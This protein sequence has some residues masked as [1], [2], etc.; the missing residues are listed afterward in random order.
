V[1]QVSPQGVVTGGFASFAGALRVADIE[2]V[3]T[4]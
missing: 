3:S 1:K 4:T 2:L